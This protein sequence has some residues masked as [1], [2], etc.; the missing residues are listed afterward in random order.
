[1]LLGHI[2]AGGALVA[3]LYQLEEAEKDLA[4]FFETKW[5]LAV[6]A[7]LDEDAL[8]LDPVDTVEAEQCVALLTLVWLGRNLITNHTLQNIC[9]HRYS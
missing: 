8:R 5:Q 9:S 6:G 2:G 7:L 4:D 1:M 3:E